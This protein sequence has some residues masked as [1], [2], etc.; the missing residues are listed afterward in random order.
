M[1]EHTIPESLVEAIKAGRAALVVGAGIGV[2]SWKQL[3]ERLNKE[4]ETRGREGDSAAAKDLDRLLHKGSLVRAVG[5]LARALGEEACDKVVEETWRTPPE[6]PHIA[7]AIA[8]LP[9]RHVWTTFPGDVLER[10]LEEHKP[11]GWPSPKVVTYQELGGLSHRRRTLVKMLG[12]FDTYVVTPHSVRRA[13]A[14]A[15]DLRDYARDLYVDG[16][17]VFVGFRYGDPDLAAMLDRVFGMFEPP[18]NQHYFL[19]AGVGP[20]TVD[21]LMAEHHM[22]VVNLAGKGGDDVAEKSVVEWLEALRDACKSAS[23]SLVQTRPDADDLDG[24]LALYRE[25]AEARDAVD[26]IERA[27]RD[28]K[29]GERVVEVLL[30]KLD[31]EDE[32][33]GKAGFLREAAKVY[34]EMVGDLKR[35]FEAITAAMHLEPADD[36]IV[37]DAER[38]AAA[39][40]D[41]PTLVSEASEITTEVTEPRLAARWWARLG[42]WYTARLDRYDY[43]LPSFRRALELDAGSLEAHRGISDLLRRQQKWSELADALRAYVEVEPDAHHKLDIYLQLG[44]LCESQLSQTSKALEAY[45]AAA[46]VGDGNDDALA[47]LERLYRRDERWGNLAKVLERRAEALDAAGETG[48]ATGVRHELATLR[49]EKLGDLEG[50]IARYEAALEKDGADREALKALVDLYDKTGRSDDYLRTLERQAKVAPEG[51]RLAI[52]RKLAAELDDKDGAEDRA[53][54]AYER[55]LEVDPSADD[56]YRGLARALR[57][58]AAWYDLVSLLDRHVSAS[59]N[60]VQRVELYLEA[61]AVHEKELDDPH[62]AIEGHMNAL[63]IDEQNRQALTALARLY[64]RTEAWDKAV[65]TLVRHAELEG[66]RGANLWAEAG[67]LALTEDGDAEAAERYLDKALAIEPEHARA[68]MTLAALH[69]KKSAWTSAIDDLLRAEAVAPQRSERIA[70]LT[71]AAEIAEQKLENTPQALALLERVLKLDPDNV[72]AGEK[73]SDRLVAAERWDDAIPVLEMLARRS[74]AGDRLERARRETQLGQAYEALH[75]TEKATKHYRLAVEADPDNLDAAL[76]LAQT[77]ITAAQAAEGSSATMEEQWK[78]IDRRYREV[79]ARHRT[80]LAD[81]QVADIWYRLGVTARALGDDRKAENAFRRAL[82]RDPGH[83]ETLQALVELGGARGEWKTVIEAKRALVDRAPENLQVKL[84]DEIGEIQRGKLKDPGTAVGAFL[85]ALKLAPQSHQLLHK[86]LECYTELKQWRRAVETLG[87]LAQQETTPARRSKYHYAAAVIARDELADTEL[88]VE[89]FSLTLDDAPS[90]P[91]AFE[92]VD[93]LLTDAKDWKNLARAVRKHLKRLGDDAEPEKLLE[94]WTRLG[95][96]YL[97]HLNNNELAIEAFEIAAQLDPDNMQRHEQL[98]D[99]YLEAGEAR[100]ADAISELQALLQF[101]P[102]RVEVYKALSKLYLEEGELDKAWC[103]AQALVFLGAASDSERALYVKYRPATFIPATRRL[104]EELWQKAVIHPR[105]DRHVGAI[106]ASTLGSIAATT[107]E[108][109]QAFGLDPAA[110]TDVE[111]DNK[112]VSRVVKYATGV[113]A[114][115]PPPMLWLDGGDGLRVANTTDKG[116]LA[117]SLLVGPSHQQKADEREL[118]FEVGKRLAYLR[119]ERFV[120]FALQTLPKIENA[121]TAALVAANATTN[122]VQVSD[123]A[124]RLGV[125][126]QKTVPGAHLEQVAALAHKLGPRLGN[127]LVTGWRSATDLTANRVGLIL[128]N[129]LESAAK[130]IATETA[131][132]SG[133]P[134]KERLR[135]LLAYA[136]SESYFAVRRHLGL[137]VR[138]EASA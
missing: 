109:P 105:E 116:R 36:A 138:A 18:R 83:E 70:M 48:R 79:L 115:D 39:T 63:A 45:E 29:D 135:D 72:A 56:A 34:E 22:E 69:E 131:S 44:D 59:K 10:A 61:A 136:A 23:V 64:R 3:L 31:L 21:E 27:A 102:D 85:E 78:E 99:L 68:L 92:A 65:A 110:R 1:P 100:R 90:T 125:S 127:G 32:H 95:D 107:A 122:E 54:A 80:G 97:D 82:E 20:V 51:E 15:V 71:R 121:F 38:L 35:A 46:D 26:A 53:I 112:L 57:G 74:E 87:E 25:D 88:A 126:M 77:M 9:F 84:L 93:K 14:R 113:L 124:R 67:D 129:D 98:A 133:L 89:R 11:E 137:T 52:L 91:K 55:I 8:E 37:G 75:R 43:A 114:L 103:L 5:F 76:G 2:P 6:L 24:W 108:A 106:F 47:A 41:W 58:K 130:A 118:A 4:L 104:T 123:D 42:T 132:T 13:L 120:T 28:A 7:T 73:V 119:P 94:L 128:A 66:N 134:V 12:S 96:L 49:H 40:G 33:A 86:L 16:T 111:R 81:G 117:P 101:A 60:P 62:R 50:A 30:G 19:G 17:L